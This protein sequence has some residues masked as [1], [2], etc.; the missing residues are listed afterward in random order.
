MK[1]DLNVNGSSITRKEIKCNSNKLKLPFSEY[2]AE[3]YLE[4]RENNN[5]GK[6]M[7]RACSFEDVPMMAGLN[8]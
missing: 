7:T 6:I 1:N 2:C 3:S 8:N 5:S 4:V